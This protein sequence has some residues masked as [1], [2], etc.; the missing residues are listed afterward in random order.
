MRHTRAG[1][2]A[3]ACAVLG[4]LCAISAGCAAKSPAVQSGILIR[5]DYDLELPAVDRLERSPLVAR[6]PM[7]DEGAWRE[8]LRSMPAHYWILDVE[9]ES[10][11]VLFAEIDGLSNGILAEFPMAAL[12]A[13][14]ED[15]DVLIYVL[16]LK[17]NTLGFG[18]KTLKRY[19]KRQTER[20]EAFLDRM[21]AEIAPETQWPWIFE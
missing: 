21:A 5:S 2:S 7:P 19:R 14:L 1:R 18:G 12:I 8:V 4:A 17:T 11:R 6:L 20:A 3:V 13:E 16:P 15:A 9:E 10:H